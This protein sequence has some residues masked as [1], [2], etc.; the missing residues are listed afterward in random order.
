[1]I[2]HGSTVLGYSMIAQSLVEATVSWHRGTGFLVWEPLP[3]SEDGSDG[4]PAADYRET[5]SWVDSS[6][7]IK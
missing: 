1:M 6:G 4:T 5:N 2:T 3:P 7:L